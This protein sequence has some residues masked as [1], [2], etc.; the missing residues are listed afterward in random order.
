M[1]IDRE[2]DGPTDITKLTAN[3]SNYANA[4]RNSRYKA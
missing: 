2:A 3:F 1:W 4:L